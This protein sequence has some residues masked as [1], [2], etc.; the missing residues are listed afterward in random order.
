[1]RCPSY[2][3]LAFISLRIS[4]ASDDRSAREPSPETAGNSDTLHRQEAVV[5]PDEPDGS[6]DRTAAHSQAH[7]TWH[8]AWRKRVSCG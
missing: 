8:P 1:C 5:G 7:R 6:Y 3:L 2:C 4:W